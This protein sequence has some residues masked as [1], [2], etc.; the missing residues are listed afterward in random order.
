M[1]FDL[2]QTVAAAIPAIVVLA[3]RC[4]IV[5]GDFF[6]AVPQGA[7]AYLLSHVIHDWDETRALTRS[8]SG[9]ARRSRPAVTCSSS[10][11]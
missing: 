2:P 5:A 3:N 6:K 4:E 8:S 10:R 7:D 11:W 9:S 1:L